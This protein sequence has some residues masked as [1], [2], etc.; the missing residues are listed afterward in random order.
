MSADRG[1]QLERGLAWTRWQINVRAKLAGQAE[2]FAWTWE[3]GAAS[4][5]AAARRGPDLMAG[6]LRRR[7]V[8]GRSR[9]EEIQISVSKAASMGQ[10]SQRGN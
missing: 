10:A 1:V 5:K 7:K 6:E 8:P 9:I 2:V 3:L 4:M